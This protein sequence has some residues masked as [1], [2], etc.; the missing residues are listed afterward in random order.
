MTTASPPPQKSPL[1]CVVVANVFPISH[2]DSTLISFTSLKLAL[3]FPQLAALL[4]NE[5]YAEMEKTMQ[6]FSLA[7]QEERNKSRRDHEFWFVHT[8]T[9]R[10][11]TKLINKIPWE[12][13]VMKAKEIV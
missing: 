10:I 11:F 1:R 2:S 13:G 5:E 8:R 3:Q 7:V 6:L 12:N 4:T 9:A